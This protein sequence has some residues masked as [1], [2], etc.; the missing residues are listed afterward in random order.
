MQAISVSQ[1]ELVQSLLTQSEL[2]TV[3]V[4]TRSRHCELGYEFGIYVSKT[5]DNSQRKKDSF[6][7]NQYLHVHT[8]QN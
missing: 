4:K 8:I 7:F 1:S 5:I 6:M 3:T 2:V